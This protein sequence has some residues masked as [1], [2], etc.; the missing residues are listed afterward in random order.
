[1][2]VQNNIEAVLKANSK[3]PV[4]TFH[5]LNEVEE[6]VHKLVAQDIHCIEITLRT[7]IAAE[8]IQHCQQIAPEGFS[9]G[10]GTIAQA[11]QVQLCKELGV[12]FMV[13][14]GS[15][16]ALVQQMQASGIPYLPG[17]MTPTEILSAMALDC[18]FLK[19]FP[20]NL[21]GGAKAVKT[22][23]GVFPA[24]KFCPTGGVNA[25]NFQ[26]LLDMKNV[27][28]VGGSWLV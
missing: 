27:L 24:V 11:E 17:V 16:A 8:A 10:V 6:V 28:S 2:S 1:M 13:S 18:Y 12:D 5:Q 9:V 23:G 25:D 4:V 7:A 20:F 14:P 26:S 15:P 21:A 3:I 22:Y 19:L